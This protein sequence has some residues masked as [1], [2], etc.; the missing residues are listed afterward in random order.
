MICRCRFA[1]SSRGKTFFKSRSVCST[2]LPFERFD[3]RSRVVGWDEKWIYVE[4]VVEKDREFCAIGHMRTVI[5]GRDGTIPPKD[6]LALLKVGQLESPA[7]PEF[8]EQW[9]TSEDQR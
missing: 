5:R 6:V 4:H 8:V 1:H 3:I 2:F 7:L 9:R